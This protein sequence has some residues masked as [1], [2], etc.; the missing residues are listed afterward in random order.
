MIGD[1]FL[2]MG[3]NND[4]DESLDYELYINNQIKKPITQIF[5][6]C[7]DQLDGFHGDL[8]EYDKFYEAHLASGVLKNTCIKKTL[9]LKR[10]AAEKLLFGDILRRL[11]NK[12]TGSNEITSFFTK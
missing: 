4:I 11:E 10:K 5:A 9:E 7:L 6:L 3:H 1:S 12:R 2:N 8:S